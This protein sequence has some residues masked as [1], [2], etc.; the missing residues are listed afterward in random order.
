MIGNIERVASLFLTKTV[1]T[2]TL[3]IVVGLLAVAYPF[4]PRHATLINAVT[5]GIPSF[6]LA[7]AP[8]T[9]IAR[10]GFVLR[11]LRLAIPS[12][13]VAGLAA[14]TTY[15]LVLG[16]RTV[17]DPSDRTAVVIT[18]CATTLWVLLLVAK[19]Y[20]WWKVVLVGSMVGLLTLA[21]VTPWG[22]WFFDL[23]VSDPTKVLTGL[24]VAGV[25]IAVITVIRVV[26]DRRMA[27]SL[28]EADEEAAPER[29]GALA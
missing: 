10:P 2:M 13:M 25:A 4:F 12:G 20:V 23:D 1:Y 16:G 19:P 14:V 26:D 5:F 3:A 11:T 6:F 29:E 17:P 9:D 18:L 21:M 8:N 27:R 28:A 15:L 22:R 24:A 7:L